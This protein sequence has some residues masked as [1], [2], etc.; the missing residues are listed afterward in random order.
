MRIIKTIFLF[1]ILT[2]F[3]QVG[4]MIYLLNLAIMPGRIR[5]V[6][7]PFY[8]AILR[9]SLHVLIYLA[10]TFLIIPPIAKT[11]G[12]VPLPA[13]ERQH[14]GPRTIMTAVLNR[15]YVRP[16][17]R[18]IVEDI[19]LSMGRSYPGM[20]VNYLDANF[21]FSFRGLGLEKGFP[22]LPHLSHSDGRKLD[23]AL[24][25]DDAAT[26]RLSTKTPSVIGYG[27]SEEP[28][29]GERNR[30]LECKGHVWYSFM[31]DHYPQGA[32]SRFTFNKGLT[33][34]LIRQFIAEPRIQRIL[35][36]PHLQTRLGL[37]SGKVMGVQCGSVRHDDHFHV[38]VN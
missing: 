29:P 19:S 14:L 15:N 26:G 33:A 37:R 16:E 34:E 27:I 5:T 1:G 11:F 17:L 13:L 38:Q 36:E 30:A 18:N 9:L 35:L 28:K 22:L 2:L 4:G 23:L 7:Q 32:K 25:Y 6:T 31:R 3:T 8:R 20:R 21:P 24:V 10:F 12:R